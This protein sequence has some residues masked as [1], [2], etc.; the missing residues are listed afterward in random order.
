ML[1]HSLSSSVNCRCVIGAECSIVGQERP[2]DPGV[3]VRQGDRR[4]VLVA[5]CHQF[6]QPALR[7]CLVL[8][9][10]DDGSRTVDHQGAQVS[11]ARLLM[12]NKVCLP[13]LEC[14]R[15]VG[16]CHTY[17]DDRWPAAQRK[18]PSLGRR[19]MLLYYL[20]VETAAPAQP[21]CYWL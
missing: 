6:A 13:P 9:K 15:G 17:M 2:H 14:C 18:T 4:H 1:L 10:A 5:P 7:L 21:R 16:S 12:P 8:G 19:W 3:L 11:V 20:M